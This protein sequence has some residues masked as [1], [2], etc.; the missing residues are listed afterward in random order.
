MV[1]FS[2]IRNESGRIQGVRFKTVRA[3]LGKLF[4]CLNLP[5]RPLRSI[6]FA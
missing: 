4:A 3:G 1:L 5:Y 2:T 6:N